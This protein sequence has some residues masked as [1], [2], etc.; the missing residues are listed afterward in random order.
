MFIFSVCN[1]LKIKNMRLKFLS[2][3]VCSLFFCGCDPNEDNGNHNNSDLSENFGAAASRDFIGQ[4]VDMD[5]HAI[6]NA[7]VKVGTSTAQT[8]V[9]GIFL[10]N[11][12]EVYEKFAYIT[13]EKAGYINGSRSLVPTAGKNNVKIMMITATPIASI[14]S[15]ESTD[16][17]LPNGTKVTF[18]GAF[19]DENG[20]A[21]SGQVNVSMFHLR[22]SDEN[23]SSLMPGMLYAQGED[24]NAKVLETFGMLN[25]ELRGSGGQKLNIN[26]GHT[27]QISMKIDDSQLGTAPA[28][29][30]LWHFD[31]AVGYWKQDG[32]ATKQGNLY[33]GNASHFSWWS[34]DISFPAVII[35]VHVRDGNGRGIP[36]V[37]LSLVQVGMSPFIEYT[38]SDGGLCVV[39]PLNMELVFSVHDMCGDIISS[40]NVGP[41]SSS[42]SLPDVTLEETSL[43]KGKLVKCNEEAVANG[44]IILFYGNTVLSAAV[45]D[46]LFDFVVPVC[47][48]E[49]HFSILGYD[50]ENA[51]TTGELN[52]MLA[53]SVTDLSNLIACTTINEYIVYQIDDRPVNYI[54]DGISTSSNTSVPFI[55][56]GMPVANN[57]R[58]RMVISG[59]TTVPGNYFQNEFD[60]T[61]RQFELPNTTFNLHFENEGFPN[62]SADIRLNS[63]GN[64]GEYIDIA[65]EGYSPGSSH[66][67]LKG[68]AHVIRDN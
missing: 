53:G 32:T 59:I 54:Y 8:D 45:D 43:V 62:Q 35:R 14:S 68:Y 55:I 11:G 42:V 58:V 3:L 17:D 40:S 65:F 29:I 37:G 16:V 30:P 24:G 51:Q 1:K 5:N 63:Y 6:Q 18:D 56:S 47:A 57:D 41:F 22:P 21:Y 7:T 66:E 26:D 36:H 12:A 31:E 28:S 2:V 49:N 23:I 34:W 9:N 46:G 4:V 13:A 20:N 44:Y 10:I 61:C 67:R 33:V 64:V 39:V 15:G 52:Q 60:F 27:A 25:V 50:Y 48:S 38:Q 19:E